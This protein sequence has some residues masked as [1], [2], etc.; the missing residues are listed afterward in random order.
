[1]SLVDK[2]SR[3]YRHALC[4][5]AL[6]VVPALA[7][8]DYDDVIKMPEGVPPLGHQIYDVHTLIFTV[9]VVIG[10]VVFGVMFY[11]IVHHRKNADPEAVLFHR[12]TRA[13]ILWTIIPVFILIGMAIPATWA[14]IK[15]EDAGEA[16]VTIRV[17]GYQWKWRY[18]YVGTKLD[19]YSNLA[20]S[21]QAAIDSGQDPQDVQHYQLDVD[22]RVV[23]PVNKKVRLL[24]SSD[25]VLHAWWVPAFGVKR[26]AIPGFVNEMWF[27]ATETGV[28][29]GQC[30]ELCGVKHGFMPI[31]V[32]VKTDEQYNNWLMEMSSAAGG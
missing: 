31:V 18:Q 22:N 30:A 1:M 32:E 3:V 21:S 2:S 8:A 17:T 28:Y 11:S 20:E 29:R 26:D 10:I 12:S 4:T 6:S 19:Y 7:Q 27:K 23:V 14:L 9:C 15:T 5:T 24:L 25:D 16:D 13:E